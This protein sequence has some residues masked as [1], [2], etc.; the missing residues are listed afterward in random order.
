MLA[1]YALLIGGRNVGLWP[2]LTNSSHLSKCCQEI[3]LS[4]N[5]KAW[6]LQA[7]HHEPPRHQP[8]DDFVHLCTLGRS[9]IEGDAKWM[10]IFVLSENF[11]TPKDIGSGL[12]TCLADV[13]IDCA[14]SKYMM[15]FT[16]AR[17]MSISL[18]NLHELAGLPITDC[19]YDEVVLSALELTGVD[20]KRERFIPCS[21]EY[22][23]YAYHLLQSADDN[24]CYHKKTVRPKS[25]HNPL[26]DIAIHERW[27]TTEEALFAK[28]CI[29]RSL[30]EEVYLVAYLACWVCV[31][32]LPGKDV[33][34]IRSSTFKIA[35]LMAN[36]RRVNLAIPVLVSIYEG[37][38]T[39]ATSPKPVGILRYDTPVASLEVGV[40]YWRLCVLSKYS[41]KAWFPCLP[42]NAKKLCSEAY[43]A[44]WAKIH[45][46]FFD[47]NIACLIRPKSIKITLK[48]KEDEDKQVDGGEN[49]PPHAFIP[50]IV[51]ECYSQVAVVEASKGKCF[52]DNVADSDSSNRD[53]HWKRQR[54]ELEDEVQSIDVGEKSET[55]HS[56]TMTPPLGM[57]LE[58]NNLHLCGVSGES[59]NTFFAKVR[60][61]DEARSL[62]FE[63]L[64][65]S[66]HEE[67]L[68][69]VKAH[70]QDVQAKASE[71]ASEIQS[72]MD[73]LE[74]V[75]EDI[76]VL[77]G[78]RT[79]LRATLK[80]KKLNHDTQA[81]VHEV[82]K[83][84]AGLESI[85]PLDDAIVEN[86]ESSR[87]NLGI[88]MEDLKSLNPF[89]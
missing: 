53:R 27:S 37:L 72:A 3:S 32:I 69:E 35:S 26:G 83:D 25:T 65:R 46:T 33:N 9:I 56:S 76:A 10:A 61:Y 1:V 36:G 87:A 23:L 88:L 21:N 31:F 64:S 44:L 11:A 28:L 86:L 38:N 48:R 7:N 49:D 58:G 8:S 5:I 30:K 82:E 17:E 47:D 12:R 60:A 13:E 18:W 42:A 50:L 22:L 74:H 84:L 4:K 66:L 2:R 6:I 80:E 14:I 54:K 39:V 67:Q 24:R 70:L 41:S 81:K 55:S 68:K 51:I 77:K 20:E 29:K 73:E 79:N 52:S 43:K 85:A 19:L 62:S 40:R 71:E 89:A 45:G 59:L 57:D 34:S 75:E 78:R 16:S 63:K 15:L